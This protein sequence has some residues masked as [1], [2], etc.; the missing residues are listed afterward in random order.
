MICTDCKNQQ[1]SKCKGGTWCDCQ[2]KDKNHKV[3]VLS[4]RKES[5]DN[6]ERREA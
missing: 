3:V 6:N 1:H 5:G 4:V 2:H